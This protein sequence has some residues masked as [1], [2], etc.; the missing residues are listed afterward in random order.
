MLAVVPKVNIRRGSRR[1]QP[2][3]I[4]SK[5]YIIKSTINTDWYCHEVF[6]F[7]KKC[8]RGVFASD[9]RNMEVLP[10]RQTLLGFQTQP[11]QLKAF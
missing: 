11:K 8:F 3:H 10:K 1:H 5:L 2:R 6:I 7:F 9:S 4:R